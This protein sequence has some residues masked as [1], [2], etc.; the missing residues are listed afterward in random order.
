MA[1]ARAKDDAIFYVR[2]ICRY[3]VFDDSDCPCE[4][5]RW[6]SLMVLGPLLCLTV[7]SK[8]VISGPTSNLFTS[9]PVPGM[10]LSGVSL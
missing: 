1:E 10:G 2:G 7:D 9:Q 3:H 5:G 4:P 8:D 6:W